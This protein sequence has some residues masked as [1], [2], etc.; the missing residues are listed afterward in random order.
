M[1]LLINLNIHEQFYKCMC[2]C[3]CVCVCACMIC[4]LDY[5][6]AGKLE[7]SNWLGGVGGVGV[8]GLVC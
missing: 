1:L 7:C 3:V 8:G 4:I 6:C 5:I 2:V